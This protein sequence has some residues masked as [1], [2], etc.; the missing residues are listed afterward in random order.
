MRVT[1]FVL[2]QL[3]LADIPLILWPDL[4]SGH[5]QNSCSVNKESGQTKNWELEE[6]NALR[7]RSTHK[8]YLRS[9]TQY[10]KI[11]SS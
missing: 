9:Q 10:C 11:Y 3:D 7:T 5:Y 2:Q 1:N 8:E 4:N 6:P